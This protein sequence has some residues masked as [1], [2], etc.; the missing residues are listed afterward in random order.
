LDL[1]RGLHGVDVQRFVGQL[2]MAFHDPPAER[3]AHDDASGV[4]QKA[5]VANNVIMPLQFK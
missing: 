2:L 1:I 4:T 5:L 3:S